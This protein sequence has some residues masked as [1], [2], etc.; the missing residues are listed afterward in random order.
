LAA[1]IAEHGPIP[2]RACVAMLSGWGEHAAS[3]RFR[4]ADGEGV[5]HFPGFH[6]EA[7][8]MLLEET[9]AVGIAV[10]TLSLDNGPSADFGVHF[11]W[12]G[13][14]RWGLECVA[15]LDRLPPVGATLFVGAPKFARAT[16][17]QTRVIALL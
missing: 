3:D 5:M 4:N 11:A 17:G 16:G 13:A 8:E 14:N 2:P 10:D 6:L 15:H 7:A 12:L 1:W 9:D